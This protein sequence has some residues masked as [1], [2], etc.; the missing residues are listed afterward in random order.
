MQQKESSGNNYLGGVQNLSKPAYMIFAL[1]LRYFYLFGPIWTD[2][3]LL[4]PFSE[5]FGLIWDLWKPIDGLFAKLS[6]NSTQLQLNLKL[7][8]ALIPLSPATQPPGHTPNR[9]PKKVD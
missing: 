2:E 9:P 7:R 3:D 4:I 1:S 5:L 8:L 6:L